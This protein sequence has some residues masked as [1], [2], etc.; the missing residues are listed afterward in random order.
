MGTLIKATSCTS[1]VSAVQPWHRPITQALFAATNG[2]FV[3]GVARLVADF[4]GNGVAFG[5]DDWREYHGVDVGQDEL[6][7]RAFRWLFSLDALTPMDTAGNPLYNYMTHY[8]FHYIP[9]QLSFGNYMSLVEKPIKGNPSPFMD[10]R[11]DNQHC[12]YDRTCLARDIRGL[13]VHD[14][15][16]WAAMRITTVDRAGSAEILKKAQYA[17]LP[18]FRI[19]SILV[20]THF[21]KTGEKLLEGPGSAT[22]LEVLGLNFQEGQGDA[23]DLQVCHRIAVRFDSFGPDV[24]D[25]APVAALMTFPCQKPQQQ[26]NCCVQ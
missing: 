24:S 8:G 4:V 21:T 2:Q 14:A 22:Q 20:R 6:P 9:A 10:W 13:G 17:T 1:A 26:Q 23:I 7:E 19:L 11:Q 15:G 16:C 3:H 5:P 25:A 12:Q 18:D